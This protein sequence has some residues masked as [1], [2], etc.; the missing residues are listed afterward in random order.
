LKLLDSQTIL[1]KELYGHVCEV[2]CVFDWNL[3]MSWS[4]LT[5]SSSEY[6]I[7]WLVVTS[8]YAITDFSD[9]SKH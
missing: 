8:N 3:I 7:L 9:S 6:S 4:Q 1:W 2:I 5:L